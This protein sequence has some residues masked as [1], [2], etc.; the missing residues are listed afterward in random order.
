[1]YLTLYDNIVYL[2]RTSLNGIIQIMQI[3]A[4]GKNFAQMEPALLNHTSS[5]VHFNQLG[6]ATH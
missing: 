1:M 4:K 5:N 2:Y 3:V 6:L